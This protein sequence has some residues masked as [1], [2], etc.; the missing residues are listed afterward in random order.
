[1]KILF[2]GS[3]PDLVMTNTGEDRQPGLHLSDILT[4]QAYERDKKYHPDAPKDFM[5]FEQGHTW[6]TVLERALSARNERV[7][8]RPE[9]IQEDGV[10]VSPDWVN[11]DADIQHEEWKATKKSSKSL[12][13]KVLDWIP[14]AKSYVRA[15][16]RQGAITRLATRFRVWC[17]MGDWTFESKGDLTLLRDYYRVDVEF[18]KRELEEHWRGTLGD[19]R[20]YGL[21]KEAPQETEWRRPRLEATVRK[22]QEM[23]PTAKKPAGKAPLRFRVKPPA[24]TSR[25][26][27]K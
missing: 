8:Y 13:A 21:L 16:A 12:D 5:I 20:R 2:A 15:L 27:K 19:A 7:G 25:R 24:D 23:P 9:Q 10:W 1:M 18:E 11:P 14:Q 6:E 22:R 4:R 3:D 17:V 26:T